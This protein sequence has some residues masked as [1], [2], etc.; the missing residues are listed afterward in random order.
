MENLIPIKLVNIYTIR[1]NI[2]FDEE[3]DIIN[4]EIVEQM[5]SAIGKGGYRSIKDILKYI[6]P[7][8][9]NNSILNPIDPIINLRISGDGRNVGKKVKHVMITCVILDDK[10]NLHISDNHFVTQ[11]VKIMIH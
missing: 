11:E 8:L 4:E 6:V 2:N 5:I 7:R 9:V 1:I 3:A 10:K